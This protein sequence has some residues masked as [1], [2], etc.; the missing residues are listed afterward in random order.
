MCEETGGELT[1]FLYR[2]HLD[3]K[4][5]N[6]ADVNLIQRRQVLWDVIS[7]TAFVLLLC[8]TVTIKTEKK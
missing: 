4:L 5:S 7:H 2:S 3:L 8:K 6:R 1:K